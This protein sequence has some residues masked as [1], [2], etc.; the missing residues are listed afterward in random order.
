MTTSG[1]RPWHGW[2]RAR[3]DAKPLS[4]RTSGPE[5]LALS[6]SLEVLASW[7]VDPV[8]S[9]LSRALLHQAMCYHWPAETVGL[10]LVEPEPSGL[11]RPVLVFI[12]EK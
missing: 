5:V 9:P 8:G 1:P 3:Q 7:Q 12:P 11:A 4:H 6:A 2:R 10:V